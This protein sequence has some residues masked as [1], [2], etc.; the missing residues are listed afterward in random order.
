MLW[1]WFLSRMWVPRRVRTEGSFQ[2]ADPWNSSRLTTFT[3]E[4]YKMVHRSVK[5]VRDSAMSGPPKFGIKSEIDGQDRMLPEFLQTLWQEKKVASEALPELLH[6][7]EPELK[8]NDF[9]V[10]GR[11]RRRL[12]EVLV[13]VYAAIA[14][15]ILGVSLKSYWSVHQAAAVHELQP[16]EMRLSE[17]QDAPWKND[18]VEV[19]QATRRIKPCPYRQVL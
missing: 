4:V 10:Y 11:G 18:S 1:L 17:W 2:A 9:H 6:K 16:A 19:K 7:I 3:I 13:W 14:L 12:I 5:V 8:K 15:G